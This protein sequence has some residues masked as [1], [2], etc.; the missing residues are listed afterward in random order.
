VVASPG[1]L[2]LAI[3]VRHVIPVNQRLW[4]LLQAKAGPWVP[5]SEPPAGPAAVAK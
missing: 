2:P 4:V 5:T 1:T 3:S